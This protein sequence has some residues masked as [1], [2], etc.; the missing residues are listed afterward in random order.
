MRFG[1]RL[2]PFWVSTSGH[3]RGRT[4]GRAGRVREL[5]GRRSGD[6]AVLP[7]QGA[8]HLP[9]RDMSEPRQAAGTSSGAELVTERASSSG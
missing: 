6:V 2:G 9:G 3:R 4:A 1:V 5:A 8:G 7:G